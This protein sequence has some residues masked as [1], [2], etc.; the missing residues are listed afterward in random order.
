[1]VAEPE[2]AAPALLTR[3]NRPGES[4]VRLVASEVRATTFEAFEV[5]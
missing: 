3:R 2:E 4:I 5:A 1:M